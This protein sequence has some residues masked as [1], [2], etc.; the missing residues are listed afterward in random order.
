MALA[1]RKEGYDVVAASSGGELSERLSQG[2]FDLV[3]S[4]IYLGDV[5][6]TDVLPAIRATNPA[7]RVILITAQGTVETAA[8]AQTAGVSEYLAKPFTLDL[9]VDKVAS[10]LS[11][12]PEGPTAGPVG[13]ESMIVGSDP[14]I[15]EVYKAVARVAPLPIPVLIRGETGTG[16]ELV[17]RAIHRYSRHGDGP[18]V[19]VNC[20]AIPE[21]L[22]ESELFGH[23][24]GSFTGATRDHKGLIE[25]ARGGTILF[26]EIGELPPL[27]QA[28]LLRFLQEGEI[29]PI[30][31]EG[32]VRVPVRVLAATHRDLRSEI[33]AGRFR[34]DFFFRLAAYEIVIPP[35]RERRGDIASLVEFFLNRYRRRYGH[36][37]APTAGPA[38]LEKLEQYSWPGNVRELEHVVQ[39]ALIDLGGLAD[40]EALSRVLPSEEDLESPAGPGSAVERAG[41]EITLEELERLH[42]IATLRRWKGNR[43]RTAASLGIERKSLYRKA[44]RLGIDLD[45]TEDES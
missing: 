33:E 31:A 17:A 25:Q 40:A 21:T 22:L 24:R 41:D 10:A 27:L 44:Q 38:A 37:L 42:I 30:G 1:L 2:N 6:A 4:D 18:F 20:G 45:P 39:R 35:L 36:P 32:G 3:L 12:R 26:D 43:T 9:L 16:K 15:V 11:A 8:A 28:K 19:A 29:R 23:R 34:Q 13:P 7:A 5:V 14:A